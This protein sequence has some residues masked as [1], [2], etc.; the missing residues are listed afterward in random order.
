MNQQILYTFYVHL[1]Y[2]KMFSNKLGLFMTSVW[3]EVTTSV[4]RMPF[5]L[6]GGNETDQSEF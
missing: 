6:G 2:N 1:Q 3:P 5:Q 4:V